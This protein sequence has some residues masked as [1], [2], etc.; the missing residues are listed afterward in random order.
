M[1]SKNIFN[2]EGQMVTGSTFRKG[3]RPAARRFERRIMKAAKYADALRDGLVVE[4]KIKRGQGIHSI[5][6]F[7]VPVEP[8]TH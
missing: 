8:T 1:A 6:K 3:G 5:N 7:V 2:S 4:P